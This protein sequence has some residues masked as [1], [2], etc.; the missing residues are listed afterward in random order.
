MLSPT[1]KRTST[2][3]ALMIYSYKTDKSA[4]KVEDKE[5]FDKAHDKSCE[6]V[7]GVNRD[8][9]MEEI[10]EKLAQGE[11]PFVVLSGLAIRKGISPEAVSV[12]YK[13]WCFLND[14][15]PEGGVK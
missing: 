10:H 4:Y 7:A 14:E 11:S 2:R 9:Q 5:E 6:E 13:L 1:D 8:T 15:Q 3:E 12:K